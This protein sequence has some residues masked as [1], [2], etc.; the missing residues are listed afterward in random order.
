MSETSFGPLAALS[1]GSTVINNAM[2]EYHADQQM[3]REKK[4][5]SL[6]N[7]Y[8]RSNALSAYQQQVQGMR[9]AGLNPAMLS[10]QTPNVAAPVTKG[11]VS[12]AENVEFDPA[13]MLLDAQRRNV[14]ADTEMKQAETAKIAGVDTE[15]VKADTGAK[16][17]ATYLTHAQTVTEGGKPGLVAAQTASTEQEAQRIKNLNQAFAEENSALGLFGQTMALQWQKESW[18]QSLPSGAKMVIDDIAKGEFDLTVGI[19]N[20]L[21]RSI[22]TDSNMN[23]VQTDK[24]QYALTRAVIEGQMKSPKVMKALSRLPEAQY[25]EVIARATKLGVET[26]MLN[27]DYGWK[28]EQKEVW[29]KN[30]PDKLYAEYQKDPSVENLAKWLVGSA[31][32]TGVDVLKGIGPAAVHG[33]MMQKG[34]SSPKSPST[35]QPDPN[36][37]LRQK[38]FEDR[39]GKGEHFDMKK[40]EHD[41]R[42][43]KI[44]GVRY[45]KKHS[46]LSGS[47][48]DHGVQDMNFK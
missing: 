40:F 46:P 22:S 37:S 45:A 31:R 20:A 43:G 39:Y 5:M 23:E 14:E 17:A 34:L 35:V 24:A 42:A 15:N 19:A 36:H 12:Q 1:A 2:S 16:K 38:Q 11:S 26:K 33:T 29:Q 47:D 27:F 32:S 7:Q 41:A 3:A 13:T 9:I 25:N 21:D 48:G 10:G 8:N 30:D 44:P 28:T 6:Q 4:L 18:Y